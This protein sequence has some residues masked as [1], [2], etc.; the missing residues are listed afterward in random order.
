M[1]SVP[2]HLRVQ[3]QG[4]ATAET[5]R[6]L[7]QLGAELD[8]GRLPFAFHEF[9]EA[10]HGWSTFVLGDSNSVH[11]MPSP[12]EYVVRLPVS[13]TDMPFW[14]G[15]RDRIKDLQHCEEALFCPE[16]IQGEEITQ[17]ARQLWCD[18]Q[19]LDE[20]DGVELARRALEAALA[21]LSC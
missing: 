7:A 6:W 13:P 9:S 5:I 14:A 19:G 15:Y 2:D 1:K 4:D 11:T 8:A 16:D 18:I 20:V 3:C 12:P 10:D 17:I 21:A